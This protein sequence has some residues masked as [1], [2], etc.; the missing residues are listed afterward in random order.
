[1]RIAAKA[2]GLR[3]RGAAS[4][5]ATPRLLAVGPTGI[6]LADAT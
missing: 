3:R 2:C 6:M 5:A 1:V 4:I